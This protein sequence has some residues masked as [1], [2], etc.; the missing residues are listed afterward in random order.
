MKSGLDAMPLFLLDDLLNKLQ[1]ILFFLFSAF[2]TS[3]VMEK[4][5][6][7]FGRK[8][9]AV[10]GA[11]VGLVGCL[12]YDMDV[13]RVILMFNITFFSWPSF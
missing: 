5:N 11:I 8:I 6:E 4:V 1:F 9:T 10:I 12:G 2:V 7:R 3:C 13:L